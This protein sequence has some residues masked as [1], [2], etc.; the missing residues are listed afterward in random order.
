MNQ[1]IERL[2]VKARRGGK[3]RCHLLTHGARH[4]VAECLTHLTEPWGLVR[5]DDNWMPQ[6]FEDREEAQLHRA[7]R[8]L[9]RTVRASLRSWWL[10]ASPSYATTPNW[11]IASTCL[12]GAQEGLLLIEAKAH[13]EE[14]NKEEAGKKLHSN[15]SDGSR[16][17]HE[18][19]GRAIQEANIG[20]N[21]TIPGWSLSRDSHYQMSNRFAWAWKLTDLGIPVILVYL[22]FLNATEMADIGNPFATGSDWETLV[23]SHSEPLFPAAVWDQKWK[24]N[25]QSFIPLIRSVECPI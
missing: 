9:P 6:G 13:D 2:P 4:G 23:N 8:L 22:G 15:A 21:A 24:L 11:D 19:I 16:K 7:S 12:I 25:G 18:Q 1:L 5:P 3:P 20:L 14:L 17:N 10:A